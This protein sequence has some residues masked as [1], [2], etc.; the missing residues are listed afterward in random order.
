MT[1]SEIFTVLVTGSTDTSNADPD[2]VEAKAA[3]VLAAVSN[4]A[5]QRTLNQRLHVDRIG[6]GF[7]ESTEQ[8]I[9][10]VGK[11][12]TK[13]VYTETQYH[14]NAPKNDNRAEVRVEYRFAPRWSLETFFGDA[15]EGGIDLFWGRAFDTDRNK[16]KSK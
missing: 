13:K 6:V 1:Q 11:H 2:E 10:T 15:A 3:S 9:L 14:H 5:L 4:P 16:R 8:P 7:G 12:V